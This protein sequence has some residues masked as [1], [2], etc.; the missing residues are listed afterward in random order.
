[1]K[2]ASPFRF[3]RLT[4]VALAMSLLTACGDDD[5]KVDPDPTPNTPLYAVIAQVSADNESQSYI[6]LTDKV[7]L[8]APLSLENAIEVPGR[9]L[10]FGIAK[11]GSLYVGG[12]D[13]AT[14][15]RYDLNS[16][17]KLEPKSTVSFAGKGVASIGEYQNQVQFVS[18]TKAYYFD[19]RTSQV[20]VWNPSDMT[21]TNAVAINNLA[22]EGA[23]TT[24][25]SHPVRVGDLI[26]AAVGWRPSASVGI[27]KQAGV[28]VVDTKTD[29]VSLVTDNRCGYVR[30]GVLGSDGKVYLATEAYGAA[31]YRVAG[32]DTPVPC[33][34]K[35]D[36]ATK[37]FDK[38][39]YR[40][41]SSFTGGAATGSL[42]PGPTGTAYLRVLDE[43]V[44][45]VAPGTHPRAVASAQAWTWWQLNLSTLAATKVEKLPAST[46]SSFLFNV[47]DNRVLFT[48]F[49][50]SSS[51]T[52][53]RDLSN[54]SGTVA[55]SSQ[56]LV[57]SFLQVR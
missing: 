35:F 21:L 39:F 53:L 29:A 34:L 36:P 13:G 4:A 28:V 23:T 51:Q 5:D 42:L 52:N 25:A 9:A 38:D 20:I 46:G 33:L 1:M 8:T 27:T 49:T 2:P 15:T 30:D 50:N 55:M 44:Y 47:A 48:E 11:S 19:G 14:I 6:A 43:S 37:S 17:G 10:G 12:S 31:V 7:D 56:G 24:F 32:G 54:Q 22:I 45:T 3:V 41:L 18:S 40:E 57:F 16:S 26:I